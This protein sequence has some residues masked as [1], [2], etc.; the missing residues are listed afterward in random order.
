M[1]FT[2]TKDNIAQALTQ[3]GGL[4]GKQTHLP[5]LSHVL[6][7]ATES[8]VSLLTT[9]LEVAIRTTIRAKVET[10]GSF[11]V[12]AKMLS[13]YIHLLPDDQIQF[14]LEG[15]ELRVKCGR[16][17]TKMKGSPPEEFP[18]MPEVERDHEFV[19]ESAPL[20]QALER[21]VV[22]VSKNEIRPE[23]SGVCVHIGTERF[24]GL[25][26]AATDS[27]RLA[28][29]QVPLLS[30]DGQVT[31]VVPS[32]T[33]YEMIRLLGGVKEGG[34]RA[35]WWVTQNQITMQVG[36]VELTSRLIQGSYPDYAQIIPKEFATRV[37]LSADE[38]VKS[39]K[40]ASLF[41]AQGVNGVSFE[42]HVPEKNVTLSSV[43]TAA[44]EHTAS[45]EADLEGAD[46]SI[47]LNYR[48]VLDGVA[49]MDNNIFIGVNSP[50]APCIFKEEG[51]DGYVYIVMPIRQ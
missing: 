14:S 8:G 2:C 39:I 24:S 13:E 5:I 46:N 7:V 19:F 18:G 1:K 10:T 29:K 3:V 38:F 22:A 32:R 51:K 36:E 49:H 50:E 44:G 42:F 48:Y 28:E 15:D 41:S 21:V 9:N 35:R 20:K 43:S 11:T 17:N 27:Y 12:P 45:V 6:L 16:N 23:L 34:A 4:A 31:C 30:G 25:T 47:L 33:V 26:V 37:S 40:T